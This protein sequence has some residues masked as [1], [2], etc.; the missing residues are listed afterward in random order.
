M[1]EWGAGWWGPGGGERERCLTCTVICSSRTVDYSRRTVLNHA[2]NHCLPCVSAGGSEG[3]HDCI[4]PFVE[5]PASATALRPG[6]QPL[7][8]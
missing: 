6:Y 3:A 4:I 8:T 2:E 1:E 7:L 5:S